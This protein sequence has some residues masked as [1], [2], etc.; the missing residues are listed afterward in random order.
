MTP[1]EPTAPGEEYAAA[2]RRTAEKRA[3]PVLDALERAAAFVYHGIG[4]GM[5]QRRADAALLR[6][7]REALAEW[8]EN[9]LDDL[10]RPVPCS[11]FVSPYSCPHCSLARL[12]SGSP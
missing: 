12:L 9:G 7:L 10:D 4:P 2:M 5:Q 3:A 1:V 6:E 8:R 11:S